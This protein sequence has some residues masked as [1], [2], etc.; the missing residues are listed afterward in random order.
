MFNQ[1]ITLTQ[2][3]TQHTDALASD[4]ALFAPEVSIMILTWITFFALLI[5]LSKFAWKPILQ[6][7]DQRENNIRAA[8]EEAEKTRAEYAQIEEKRKHIL[9]HADKQA[10]EMINQS[11]HS[12]QRTAKVIE[13]RAKEDAKIILENAQREIETEQEKSANYLREKST[14]TAVQLATKILQ[15]KLDTKSHQQLVDRLIDEI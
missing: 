13:D 15:E 12:A 8:V 3:A 11:R 5:V 4:T 2:S 7:L 9:L 10:H 6:N 1:T 14:E